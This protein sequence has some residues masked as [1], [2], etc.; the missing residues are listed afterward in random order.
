[1]NSVFVTGHTGF[2]GSWFSAC[3]IRSGAAVHGYA[4][5]PLP[6]GFFDQCNI[7]GLCESSTIADIRDRAALKHAMTAAKPDVVV[8]MAAQPLVRESYANPRETFDVNV[9]GTLNVIE[10]A[11]EI[12]VEKVMVIT[13]DK[14]YRNTG[15]TTG[16]AEDAPLGGHDPYSASKAMAEV[17]TQSWALSFPVEGQ[18]IVTVRAGNVIGGGDRSP[19][20]LLP[21]LLT[22]V[23]NGE[24][25]VLR[26]PEA[27]RPWQHVLDVTS[28]YLAVLRA[29]QDF[30]TFD[31]WNIGPNPNERVTVREVAETAINQWG[32]GS[33]DISTAQQPHEA[34]M[35][36]IDPAKA[37]R[38]LGWSS[39]LTVEQ[40]VR[41]TV[42]WEKKVREGTNAWGVSLGQMEEYE[43]LTGGPNA[44]VAWLSL[45]N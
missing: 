36:V 20:R 37:N 30:D 43:A 35:L 22:S 5:D 9:M 19:D 4:L 34:G 12:G 21:D 25:L 45:A 14:V 15:S 26:Y 31:Q 7:A 32:S 39:T 41:W 2:K 11:A 29:M 13:S 18:Q 42:D 1:M 44:D 28:G 8:H 40:A 38:E 17:L 23:V 16:Y 10:A 27:V 33:I 3:A 24:S 6:G